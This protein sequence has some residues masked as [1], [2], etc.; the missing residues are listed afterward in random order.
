MPSTSAL[1]RIR[2]SINRP[3][4]VDAAKIDFAI[5]TQCGGLTMFLPLSSTA[6]TWIETGGLSPAARWLGVYLLE[7]QTAD[8]AIRRMLAGGLVVRIDGVVRDELSA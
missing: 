4:L 2:S 8:L 1:P 3:H 6:E 7:D 5:D